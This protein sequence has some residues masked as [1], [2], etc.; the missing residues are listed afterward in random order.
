MT[1]SIHVYRLKNNVI[2]LQSEEDLQQ[3]GRLCKLI[4]LRKIG[5]RDNS[6]CTV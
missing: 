5:K 4:L 6:I 1:A 2:R 3:Q